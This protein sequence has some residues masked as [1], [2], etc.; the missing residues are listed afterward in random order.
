MQA[1]EFEKSSNIE[2][3][4]TIPTR[5]VARVLGRGGA[6]IKEIKE[7]TGALIDVDKSVDDSGVTRVILHGTKEAI[8]DAKAAILDI[9]NQVHEETTDSVT[10]ENKFHR[11]IIGSGGQGLRD[12]IVRC[13]GPADGKAQAGLIRL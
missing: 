4:F 3:K 11:T 1:Y 7:N 2:S 10:I 13:G 8:A 9:A 12:L 6:T 5:A